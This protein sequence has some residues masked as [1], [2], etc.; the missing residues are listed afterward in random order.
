MHTRD[1]RA[2]ARSRGPID[3]ETR[4]GYAGMG[5]LIGAFD[6]AYMREAMSME[7]RFGS[8]GRSA[9]GTEWR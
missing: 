1:R 7:R 5:A 8:A 9:S 4:G 3:R 2:E 6:R